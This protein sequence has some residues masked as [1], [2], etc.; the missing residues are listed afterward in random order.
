MP[1]TPAAARADRLPRRLTVT[2]GLV[3]IVAFGSWFYGYGVLVSPI[4]T[5]TG[6]SES[7]LSTAYGLGL[8]ASGFVAVV[9]GRAIDT[10][11]PRLVFLVAAVA[12][13]VGTAV[14]ATAT[15]PVVFVIGAIATQCVVGA[16]GYYTAVHASI[17]RLAPADRTRAI[18]VNTLW[19]AFASPVFLPLMGLMAQHWGWRAAIAV[20]GGAV[21][22]VFLGAAAVV[23]TTPTAD[24]GG[25]R[26]GLLRGLATAVREPLVRRLLV[27]AVCGGI[28]TSVLF[29]YQVPAMVT[30]GLT[31]GVASSLAGLRGLFQLAGR[32]PLPWLVSRVGSE[33]LFRGSLLLIGLSSLLLLVSGQLAVA[34]VFVVLAGIAVGMFSTLESIFTADVVDVRTIGLV[35]GAYSMSRGIGAAIGPIGAGVLTDATSGRALALAIAA[36]IGALGAL[37]IPRRPTAVEQA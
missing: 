26:L 19:G 21:V 14:T 36:V 4:A 10:A 34:I 16:A 33:P 22:A 1:R 2:F 24:D 5:N 12:A 15:D 11:G 25:P 8:L 17:A 7:T 20:V 13:G 27:V 29:L 37:A 6:W 35:L 23:P 28:V 32:L 30:A 9:A 18:T 31:L 3:V